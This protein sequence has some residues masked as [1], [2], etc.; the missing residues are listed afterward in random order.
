M[1]KIE[2]N[3][4]KLRRDHKWAQIM[5]LV[6]MIRILLTSEDVVNPRIPK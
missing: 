4:S 6:F 1:V 2:W 5:L 3:V